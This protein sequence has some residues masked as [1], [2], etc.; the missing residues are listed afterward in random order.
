MPA[1]GSAPG[2]E[3][4]D[5]LGEVPGGVVVT[6]DDNKQLQP[7]GIDLSKSLAPMA[8]FIARLFTLPTEPDVYRH[9]GSPGGSGRN[10]PLN[11]CAL[12]ANDRLVRT[13]QALLI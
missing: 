11:F 6:F 7:R 8:I 10:G 4:S 5:D 2:S 1:D 13:S 3:V 12:S 9:I